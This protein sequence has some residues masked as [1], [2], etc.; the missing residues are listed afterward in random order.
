MSPHEASFRPILCPCYGA[1]SHAA[2]AS[3]APA[4]EAYIPRYA[5]ALE[6]Y[7]LPAAGRQPPSSAADATPVT[8]AAA[9]TTPTMRHRAHAWVCDSNPPCDNSDLN[10]T[11]IV[12]T[13]RTAAVHAAILARLWERDPDFV[14]HLPDHNLLHLCAAFPRIRAILQTY[15]ST[16]QARLQ[17][18]QARQVRWAAGAASASGSEHATSVG[19]SS[20]SEMWSDDEVPESD[21]EQGARAFAI[22]NLDAA[23]SVRQCAAVSHLGRQPGADAATVRETCLLLREHLARCPYPQAQVR[24]MYALKQVL[25]PNAAPD[26]EPFLFA[27]HPGV[28]GCA[29]ALMRLMGQ[30]QACAFAHLWHGSAQ[31]RIEGVWGALS[32]CGRGEARRQLQALLV[33][34]A[35]VEPAPTV[36]KALLEALVRLKSPQAVDIASWYALEADPTLARFARD[37]LARLGV[38]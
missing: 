12:A 4:P 20:G 26:I 38:I 31:A 32:N 2:A 1:R 15:D 17:A 14:A 28:A 24:G 9:L 13:P 8:T 35:L 33:L 16:L 25:G 36:R 3:A 22:G 5:Q 18:L 37:K 11:D 34:Q 29:R 6:A 7:D 23:S 10:G 19:W 21:D 27:R 30:V